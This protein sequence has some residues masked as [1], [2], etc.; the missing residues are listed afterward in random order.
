[1][2]QPQALSPAHK[3]GHQM[4]A[5]WLRFS[6]PELINDIVNRDAEQARAGDRGIEEESEEEKGFARLIR[7]I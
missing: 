3:G 1:M 7:P 4:M 5:S 2:N 6:S